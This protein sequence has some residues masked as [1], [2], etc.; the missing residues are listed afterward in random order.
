[1][2]SFRDIKFHCFLRRSFERRVWSR[3]LVYPAIQSQCLGEFDNRRVLNQGALVLIAAIH[4]QIRFPFQS[5]GI[6]NVF[7]QFPLS[8]FIFSVL[9][10]NCGQ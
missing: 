2:L 3:S 5:S 10:P 7:N 8:R 9:L 4:K 6:P 1:M